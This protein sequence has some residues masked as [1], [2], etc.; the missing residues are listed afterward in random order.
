MNDETTI[1]G[2]AGDSLEHSESESSQPASPVQTGELEAADSR[3]ES[4]SSLPEKFVGKSAVEIAASYKELEKRLGQLGSEKS[5]AEKA[6]QEHATRVAQYEAYIAGL[7]RNPS[8]PQS[9]QSSDPL[10]LFEQAWENEGPKEAIKKIVQMQQQSAQSQVVQ[11]KFED[12]QIYV[13]RMQKENP[14][15]AELMPEMQ[16]VAA[17]LEPSLSPDARYSRQAVDMVYHIAKARNLSKYAQAEAAKVSAQTEI[18]K[19][20]KRQ[21]VSESS[22]GSKGEMTKDVS[23]M[24]LDE[25][26]KTLGY[27][28][29]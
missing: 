8:Q 17:E 28:D 10:E 11:R 5:A 27:V 1:S 20:K 7:Q 22:S 23:D 26:R 21:S 6:A 29:R 19:S 25:L 4:D 2:E 15:F 13:Q 16:K 3:E 9:H 12:T 18:Q 24:S 14:D